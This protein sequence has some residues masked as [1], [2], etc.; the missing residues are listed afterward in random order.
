MDIYVCFYLHVCD[1]VVTVM[2]SS[3]YV[4]MSLCIHV[5][6]CWSL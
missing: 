6:I 2:Y 5:F 1:Y 4:S 3:L